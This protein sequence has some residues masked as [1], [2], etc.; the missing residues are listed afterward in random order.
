M[1]LTKNF[2]SEE[3]A[4]A[5]CSEE[6]MEMLFIS[7]LQ[8]ARTIAG[9]PF[10]INSG[11]RCKKH[12]IEVGGTNTSSHTLGRAADISAPDSSKRF[13]ILSALLEA[14]F[15]RLGIGD[16]FI[17]VDNDASKSPN[18]IWLYS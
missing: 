1:K 16:A 18:I 15:T 11:Y 8:E 14:G 10:K 7:K 17:H 9:I 2:L 12:N 13:T 5:C 3:F 4:C 6:H